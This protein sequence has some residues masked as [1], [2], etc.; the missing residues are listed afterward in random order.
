MS[1][2][3][4]NIM[5]AASILKKILDLCQF[6]FHSNTTTPQTIHNQKFSIFIKLRTFL[7]RQ[8]SPGPC[9]KSMVL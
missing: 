8:Q 7:Y 3:I 6:V 9:C 2:D 1:P 5:M 4:E